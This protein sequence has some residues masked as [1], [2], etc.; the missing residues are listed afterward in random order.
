MHA[1]LHMKNIFVSEAR[2][3]DITAIIDWQGTTVEPAFMYA[4]ETPDC[5]SRQIEDEDEDEASDTNDTKSDAAKKRQD[6]LLCN[7]TFEA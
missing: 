7:D 1:D 4:N 2:P 3:F 6:A 5:A